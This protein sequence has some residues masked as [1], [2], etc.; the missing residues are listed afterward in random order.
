MEILGK[1][2]E[3]VT[4]KFFQVKVNRANGFRPFGIIYSIKR[5]PLTKIPLE[6]KHSPW[7]WFYLNPKYSGSPFTIRCNSEDIPLI[8]NH[9][10]HRTHLSINSNLKELLSYMYPQI[11]TSTVNISIGEQFDDWKKHQRGLVR[12]PIIKNL[13]LFSQNRGIP[14]SEASFWKIC[15]NIDSYLLR[16]I[17]TFI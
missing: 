1:E 16:Y 13:K 3:S 12:Y 4:P 7:Y 8:G 11:D 2:M 9:I 17:V 10:I 5:I 14:V 15:S 6:V